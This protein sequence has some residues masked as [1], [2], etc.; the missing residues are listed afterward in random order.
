MHKLKV[1]LVAMSSRFESG[2]QRIE[3]ILKGAIKY[4]EE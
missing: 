2:G 4:L 3:E 1:A